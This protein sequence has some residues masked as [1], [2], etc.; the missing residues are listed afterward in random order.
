MEK[1]DE[2]EWKWHWNVVNVCFHA[3]MKTM[4]GFSA[5]AVKLRAIPCSGSSCSCCIG[6][7]SD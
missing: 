1:T 2:G 4:F 5:L 3:C 6:F 7:L